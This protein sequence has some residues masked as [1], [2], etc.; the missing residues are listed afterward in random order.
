M[1]GRKS[2]Y[3][4]RVELDVVHGSVPSPTKLKVFTHHLGE[5]HKRLPRII[6]DNEHDVMVINNPDDGFN[7]SWDILLE[8]FADGKE[9]W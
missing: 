4:R 6:V 5:F 2:T 1:Q 3:K 9:T 7:P 8:G